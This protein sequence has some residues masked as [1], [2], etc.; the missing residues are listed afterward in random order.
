MGFTEVVPFL[1]SSRPAA[2]GAWMRPGPNLTEQAVSDGRLVTGQN[3]QSSN[4]VARP[5]VEAL[6]DRAAAAA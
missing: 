5:L 1:L 4:A 3:P 6:S 2:L